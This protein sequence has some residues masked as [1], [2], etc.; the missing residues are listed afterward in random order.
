MPRKRSKNRETAK[1][2]KE[3]PAL[4]AYGTAGV[5]KAKE[6]YEG[7]LAKETYEEN[8]YFKYMVAEL[9]KFS[10]IYPTLPAFSNFGSAFDHAKR[11]WDEVSVTSSCSLLLPTHSHS[12]F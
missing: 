1:F 10:E 4:Y 7:N 12:L 5:A 3:N 2:T 6:T 8:A 9:T 11:V